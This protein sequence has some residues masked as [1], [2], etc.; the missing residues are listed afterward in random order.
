MTCEWCKLQ[1]SCCCTSHMYVIN[2][3]IPYSALLEHRVLYSR[4]ACIAG[5]DVV[6]VHPQG[7]GSQ[8]TGMPTEI[9]VTRVPSASWNG[10]C[11]QSLSCSQMPLPKA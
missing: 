2:T 11:W 1:D 7:F 4:P 3:G 5:T 10:G 8:E 6:R 9:L